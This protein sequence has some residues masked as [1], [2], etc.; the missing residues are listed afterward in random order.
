[1]NRPLKEDEFRD[2]LTKL[3]KDVPLFCEQKVDEVIERIIAKYPNNE[4]LLIDLI[5]IKF[6]IKF[7]DYIL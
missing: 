1:M 3:R 4:Q 5:E 7:D 6:N 2:I